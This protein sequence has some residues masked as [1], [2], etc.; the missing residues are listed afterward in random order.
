MTAR[1][2][3][4]SW[5]VSRILAHCA[6]TMMAPEPDPDARQRATDDDTASAENDHQP[7]HRGEL[8]LVSPRRDDPHA[9]VGGTAVCSTLGGG[10]CGGA[11][12]RGRRLRLASPVQLQLVSANEGRGPEVVWASLPQRSREIVLALLARL[13]DSGAVEEDG[14]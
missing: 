11:S 3:V 9:S 2:G 5:G 7:P 10:S 6:M 8:R 13:I 1:C 4:L 14:R 12:A